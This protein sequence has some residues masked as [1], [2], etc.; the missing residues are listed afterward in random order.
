MSTKLA[1]GEAKALSIGITRGKNIDQDVT[2]NFNELPKG[3]TIDPA[4][5]VIKHGDLDAKVTLNAAADAALGDFTVK[6][7]G[8]PTTGPDASSDL[9]ITVDKA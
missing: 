8:H 3:V 6:V 2:L 7:K 5:P 4:N 1:Q 9:K